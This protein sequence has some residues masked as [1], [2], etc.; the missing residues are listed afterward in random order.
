MSVNKDRKH[1]D[2]KIIFKLILISIINFLL[3]L[4]LDSWFLS[5]MSLGVGIFSL[6]WIGV[7]LILYLFNLSNL[8][9]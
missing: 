7:I 9:D 2:K 1:N 4:F 5:Q 3:Y 8:Q 6:F